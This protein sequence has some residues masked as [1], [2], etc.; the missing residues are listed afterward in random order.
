MDNTLELT[1]PWSPRCVFKRDGN[2]DS[3]YLV[4]DCH[5]AGLNSPTSDYGS[6]VGSDAD[7][8]EGASYEDVFKLGS[9]YANQR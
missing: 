2:M 3:D 4:R 9:P 8:L 7:D 1:D 5:W 6:L